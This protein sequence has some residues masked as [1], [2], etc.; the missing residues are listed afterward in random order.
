M[1]PTNVDHRKPFL[2]RDDPSAE[3]APL[4]QERNGG[5]ADVCLANKKRGHRQGFSDPRNSASAIRCL[6]LLTNFLPFPLDEECQPVEILQQDAAAFGEHCTREWSARAR[7][8][9][10]WPC[11]PPDAERCGRAALAAVA[12]LFAADF[13]M[14]SRIV[15]VLCV[16]WGHVGKG[17]RASGK[18]RTETGSDETGNID[19]SCRLPAWLPTVVVVVTSQTDVVDGVAG[20]SRPA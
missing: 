8:V 12:T 13:E 5:V 20:R 2:K 10:V 6:R 16:A 3:G 18:R 11:E 15:L 14:D 19:V 9:A 1:P 4:E 7:H 17:N